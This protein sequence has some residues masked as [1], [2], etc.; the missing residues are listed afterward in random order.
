[1]LSYY[2]LFYPDF[3]YLFSTRFVLLLF[4]VYFQPSLQLKVNIYTFKFGKKN[5]SPYFF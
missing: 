1:M 5:N 4:L 2:F 3:S